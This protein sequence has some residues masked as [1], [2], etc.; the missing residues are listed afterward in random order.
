MRK[1]YLTA[2]L[3]AI[4]SLALPTLSVAQI[5]TPAPSPFGKVMQKIGLAEVTVEYSRPS[6]KGRKLFVDVEEWGKMWR[7]GANASTK[8]SFSEDMTVAGQEVPAGTYALYSIP[9]PNEWTFMLYNDLKLGGNVAKYDPG[10]EQLRFKAK[11]EMLP[12]EV[13]TMTLGFGDLKAD[14][15]S[16]YL[17][18]GKY[19]V[20][21]DIKSEVDKKVMT[22]IESVM[23]GPS[24]GEYYSASRYYYSNDKDLNQALKWIR[25]ANMMDAKFWQL[26]LE[27]Q[28]LAK[29]G[30]YDEAIKQANKSTQLAIAAENK[31]YP[32][33]NSKSITEWMAMKKQ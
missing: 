2:M 21:F 16:M 28:I 4:L 11:T 9:D 31:A 24:R 33:M 12:M 8:I 15:A 6:K 19:Y 30:Q 22:Q 25:K 1:I 17:I 18:W 29:M 32:K 5:D 14:Q 3:S 10:K 23:N 20:D 13:E 26:R 7:T 27:A